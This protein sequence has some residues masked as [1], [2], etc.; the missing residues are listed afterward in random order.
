MRIDGDW[1]DEAGLG[2]PKLLTSSLCFRASLPLDYYKG[3][4]ILPLIIGDCSEAGE[5]T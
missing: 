4:V 3:T 2:F 5:L 1:G